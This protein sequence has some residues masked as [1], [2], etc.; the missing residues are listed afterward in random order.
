MLRSFLRKTL[1]RAVMKTGRGFSLLAQFVGETPYEYADYLRQHG[2][3]HAMGRDVMIVRGA[4]IT[5]PAYV[6]IG[7]N[8]CLSKCV[9]IGHDGSIGVLS[10]AYNIKLE[11]VGKID[12]R[13]NVFIGWGAIVLPGVTIGPNSVVAAGAVVSS[14]VPEGWVVGGVPAKPIVRTEELV[15]RFAR[16]AR[17]VPWWD[18]LAQR[19]GDFDP[20]ME[21][22]LVRRRVESFF[23]PED[24]ENT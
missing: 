24:P 13:D 2:G 23:P 22:E 10:R 7:N 19:Q 1:R 21:D 17:D 3:L 12:V 20:E 9:L 18:L 4:E 15:A 16:E 5:D 8:V 11:R 14:D 6:K